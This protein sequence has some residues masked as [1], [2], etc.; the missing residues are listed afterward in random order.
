VTG[1]SVS[2]AVP[3]VHHCLVHNTN[4]RQQSVRQDHTDAAACCKSELVLWPAAV[5]VTTCVEHTQ[6]VPRLFDVPAYTMY[7]VTILVMARTTYTHPA[8]NTWLLLTSGNNG[9][10]HPH[11]H[12]T[13]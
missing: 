2:W 1:G 8:V 13:C 12:L 5:C 7:W 10:S 4:A 6:D 3:R 9:C 11:P